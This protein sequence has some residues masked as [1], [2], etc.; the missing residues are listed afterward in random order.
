MKIITSL[1]ILLT[2]LLSGRCISQT[3]G[4]DSEGNSTIV[5]PSVSFTLDPGENLATFHFFRDLISKKKRELE[6]DSPAVFAKCKEQDTKMNIKACI[7]SELK[8]YNENYKKTRFNY[9]SVGADLK[10]S[11]KNGIGTFF[12]DEKVTTSTS[13]GVIIGYNIP[14]RVISKPAADRLSKYIDGIN[15]LEK[16][17][18]AEKQKVTPALIAGAATASGYSASYIGTVQA[19]A[20]EIQFY[21][22]IVKDL[23]DKTQISGI[24]ANKQKAIAEKLYALNGLA[25][26][27]TSILDLVDKIDKIEIFAADHTDAGGIKVAGRALSVPEKNTIRSHKEAIY[28]LYQNLRQL[29]TSAFNTELKKISFERKSWEEIQKEVE[30]QTEIAEIESKYIGGQSAAAIIADASIVSL[31]GHYNAIIGILKKLKEYEKEEGQFSDVFYEFV[32]HNKKLM[33]LRAAFT[34]SDFKYDLANGGQT[35]D[36]RFVDKSFNGYSVEFGYTY[37]TRQYNFLG[38]SGSIN[39]AHNLDALTLTTFK[40]D[41]TDPLITDGKFSSS[42]EIK[43]MSGSYDRFLRYDLNFDFIRLL[44]LSDKPDDTID[45][46]QYYLSINPYVRHRIYDN[47]D[48]LKNNTILGLGVHAY[49]SK[50]NKI[51]GGLFVQADDTFGVNIAEGES[52]NIGKRI[53]FGIIVKFSLIGLKIEEKK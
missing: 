3:L 13:L 29:Y 9:L 24:L 48:K 6:D 39:Y 51:M 49:N 31:T 10:G 11:T 35:V 21:E 43:A 20:D 40:L 50:D 16:Q 22:G 8:A 12:T 23:G 45:K 34:G 28:T 4:Q 1:F 27:I 37:T 25:P 52:S 2:L 53:S 18:S 46:S 7:D 32:H 47:A 44:R 42:E 33:Y 19:K 41:K 36:A 38:I 5:A 30:Q 17:L 15:N 14:S 26:H